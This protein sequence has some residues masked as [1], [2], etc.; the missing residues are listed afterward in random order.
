MNK[1]DKKMPPKSGGHGEAAVEAKGT[2]DKYR[3]KG[4]EVKTPNPTPVPA[5]IVTGSKGHGRSNGKDAIDHHVAP[6]KKQ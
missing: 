4:A 6:T 2:G 1:K 3:G 5:K